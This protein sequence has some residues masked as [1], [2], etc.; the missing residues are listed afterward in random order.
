MKK[1]TLMC[2]ILAVCLIFAACSTPQEN[3]EESNQSKYKAG[4][5]VVASAVETAPTF[6]ADI[7]LVVI[8][9]DGKIVSC[10][11]DTVD[12]KADITDVS[13]KIG[14]AYPSKAAL[15]ADYGM[16][17]ASAIQKEWF[18]QAQ[19]FEQYCIGKT[20]DQLSSG[21]YEGKIADLSASCTI[22]VDSLV[23]AVAKAV[24]NAN[25]PVDVTDNI[26]TGLYINC[27][28]GPSSADVTEDEDGKLVYNCIVGGAVTVGGGKICAAF[29]DEIESTV[30]FDEEGNS[31][32]AVGY[33]PVSKYE[34]GD[35]Y[36]MKTMSGINKEWFEQIDALTEYCV[37][38]TGAEINAGI[39]E[40]G[41]AA[42]LSASCTVYSAGYINA[43][44]KALEK[45][46]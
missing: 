13:G 45:A 22:G 15:G 1:S 26:K 40:D 39:G 43:I 4:L 35:N 34:K 5:A 41:K 12:A 20:A 42:D 10:S 11:V 36:G 44:I 9:T 3:S 18:E 23:K 38:K 37:G 33:T 6:T 29:A 21:V 2:L 7:A 28:L 32:T 31:T 27:T 24:E 16:K 17:G 46:Q 19:A 8:D 30:T 25:T 14:T